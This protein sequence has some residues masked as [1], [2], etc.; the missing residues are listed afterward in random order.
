MKSFFYGTLGVFVLAA[1]LCYAGPEPAIIQAQ[2]EWTTEVR[3]EPLQQ[4]Q[5]GRKTGKKSASF[6]Y[7]ILTVT[8]TEN[9]DVDFFPKCELMTDTFEIISAETDVPSMVFE[10]IKKRHKRKYPFLEPLEKVGNRILQGE[11]NTRDI[12]IVWPDFDTKA[13]NIKI[14]ITGLSNETAVIEHPAAKDEIGNPVKVFLRKTLELSCSLSGDPAFRSETKLTQ[15][16][17]R[18]IMR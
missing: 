11:D 6:W 8:N 18:W 2:H 4:I 15:K 17:K 7:V 14:F 13:K 5:L 9:H 12:A 3:F 1:C 10:Q 16:D